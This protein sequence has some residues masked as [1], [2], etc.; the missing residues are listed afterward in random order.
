MALESSPKHPPKTV[1][2]RE[3]VIVRF[4]GDS[5]DGM[6]HFAARDVLTPGIGCAGR[7][8]SPIGIFRSVVRDSPPRSRELTQRLDA[9]RATVGDDELDA[10][11]GAGNTWV[12]A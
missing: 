8:S 11:L 6:L 9:A 4:A 12:V 5:G 7:F 10:L 2:D 3:R 1:E